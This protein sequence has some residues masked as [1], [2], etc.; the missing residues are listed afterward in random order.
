M[1]ERARFV[2]VQIGGFYEKMDEWTGFVLPMCARSCRLVVATIQPSIA[3]GS[4]I[5]GMLF[6]GSGYRTTFLASHA[7]VAGANWF[8]D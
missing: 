6:D 8:S 1:D 4:T 5:G 7:S 2:P 3:L